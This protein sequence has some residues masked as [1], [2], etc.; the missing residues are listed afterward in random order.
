MGNGGINMENNQNC[1][2]DTCNTKKPTSGC[3]MTD[4]IMHIADHA[5]AEL[6]KE[7]MK[8][9]FEKQMGDKMNKVAIASVNA[10]I[11]YHTHEMEGKIKC[12]E[13]KNK[14]KQA[15]MA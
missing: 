12:E 8:K 2:E 14:L 11:E 5:W 4:M 1:C 15:F 7:K 3:E 9:E 10:S 13:H 6:M